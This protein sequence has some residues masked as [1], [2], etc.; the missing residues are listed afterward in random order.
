MFWAVLCFLREIILFPFSHRLI[1]NLSNGQ[2]DGMN[3][4]FRCQLC[5]Q[6]FFNG[7]KWPCYLESLTLN[8]IIR[9]YCHLTSRFA[10]LRAQILNCWFMIYKISWYISINAVFCYQLH[11]L[12][13]ICGHMTFLWSVSS[14][15]RRESNIPLLYGIIRI[16]ESPYSGIFYAV[17]AL[18][19]S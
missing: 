6:Y 16:R 15:V 19:V 17:A 2:S 10:H 9:L 11:S 8:E 5:P 1:F 13:K 3:D 18:I 7:H 14:R 4:H 12:H